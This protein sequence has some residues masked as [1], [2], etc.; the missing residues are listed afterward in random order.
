MIVDSS[1]ENWTPIRSFLWFLRESDFF[2][3]DC[4]R[5]QKPRFCK[6][7]MCIPTQLV[8]ESVHRPADKVLDSDRRGIF[9]KNPAKVVTRHV[10][11]HDNLHAIESWH[12]FLAENL[13]FLDVSTHFRSESE[14]KIHKFS[15]LIFP[16]FFSSNSFFQIFSKH[17]T[18]TKTPEI[19]AL[20]HF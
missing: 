20:C 15:F 8:K 4:D 12:D 16:D 5:Y 6:N 19:E 2:G 17:I 1:N 11:E 10:L 13:L 9:S 7:R 18:L 3:A 14:K